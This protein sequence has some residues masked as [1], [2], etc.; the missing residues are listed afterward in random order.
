[1]RPLGPERGP[2][3]ASPALRQERKRWL[4][5]CRAFSLQL[6]GGP[7]PC[8]PGGPPGPWPVA[9]TG[10]APRRCDVSLCRGRVKCPSVRSSI[11][12]G[13]EPSPSACRI[14]DARSQVDLEAL[15][16]IEGYVKTCL[17]T[18]LPDPRDGKE[19]GKSQ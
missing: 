7:P 13:N 6:P 1:M 12:S 14:Q 15:P 9:Q 10:G 11:P 2:A 16:R 3:R 5:A 17:S 8:G 19:G 18:R 4:D